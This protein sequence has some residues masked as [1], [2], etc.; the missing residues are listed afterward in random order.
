[1]K[2]KTAIVTG[3]SGQDGAYLCEL[4]ISKGYNVMGA[5]RRSSEREYWRLNYLGINDKVKKID[6]ELS[7]QSLITSIIEK[8]KPDH[9]YNLAAMSF[10]GTSFTQ[11]LYTHDVNAMGVV[12]ILDAVKNQSP[13]TK[14]YQA[15]TSEMFGKVQ[16]IPQSEDTPFHPR[17]PYGVAKLSAFWQT[18]NYRE[19]YDLF[20][21]NGILFNH[22]S[23]LRGN[24]FV[25]KKIVR[26]ALSI[27]K[28]KLDI[29]KLGN[30]EAKRDWGY[31]KDYVVAMNMILESDKP[32]DFVV[33]TG[34]TH[35]VK[36]FCELVF[37]QY[38]YDI[39]WSGKGVT[40]KG[41]DKKSGNTLI[42]VSED[43]FRPAEVDI[44]ISDP[45]KIKKSLGWE[46]ETSFEELV[47]LMCESELSISD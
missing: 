28:G 38:G 30:L 15:S 45:S 35:T 29:L 21:T 6:F 1:M 36:E 27:K 42:E 13:L 47:T 24:E 7:E 18:V 26:S 44:L 16:A 32:D 34:E 20:A 14:F 22:E 5:D 37:K 11:P 43:F 46:P 12:R 41:I 9:F 2:N 19:S 31:A 40:E 39:E 8:Y 3:I 10:V 17:S 23:P 33:G 25:T 4:L